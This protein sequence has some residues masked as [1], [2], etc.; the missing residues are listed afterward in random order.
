MSN[1]IRCYQCDDDWYYVGLQ[2]AYEDP[3]TPGLYLLPGQCVWTKTPYTLS[4]KR[5]WRWIDE[6]WVIVPG[7]PEKFPYLTGE[8]PPESED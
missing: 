1:R 3:L 4:G 6:A 7:R 2:W 8:T 5:E